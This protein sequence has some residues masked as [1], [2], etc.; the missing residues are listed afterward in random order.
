MCNKSDKP[1]Y[2]YIA[3]VMHRARSDE[4][5]NRGCKDEPQVESAKRSDFADYYNQIVALTEGTWI[6]YALAA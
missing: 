4:N 5:G 3:R 6:D 1:Q 2:C